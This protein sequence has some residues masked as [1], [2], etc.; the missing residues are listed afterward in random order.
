MK[1]AE[2]LLSALGG[3]LAAALAA[4]EDIAASDLAFSLGQ[5]VDVTVD[6][7]RGGGRVLLDD[8]QVPVDRVAHDYLEAGDWI[9]PLDRA[10]IALGREPVPS[11]HADVMLAALRRLARRDV[12]VTVGLRDGGRLDG[13]VSRAT[14]AHLVVRGQGSLAVPLNEVTYVRRA[15]GGSADAP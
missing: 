11:V 4:E 13:A 6:L 1:E 5:D 8:L 9:V 3:E 12:R 15:R 7:V 2:R 10:V 14:P